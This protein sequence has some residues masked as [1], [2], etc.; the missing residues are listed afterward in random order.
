MVS[1]GCARDG[2]A[3]R[4]ADR[5]AEVVLSEGDELAQALGLDGQ[6]ETLCERVEVGAEGRELEARDACG[7]ENGAE[8]L[9]EQ[10]VAVVVR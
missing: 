3:R 2:S 1:V 6:H 5:Q 9:G 4:L 7:A 8:R 10:R